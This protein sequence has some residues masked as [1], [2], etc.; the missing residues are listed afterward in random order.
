[1][2]LIHFIKFIMSFSAD[3]LCFLILLTCVGCLGL[4]TRQE[5]PLLRYFCWNQ[6]SQRYQYIFLEE[7]HPLS[8]K[9]RSVYCWDEVSSCFR[10]PFGNL[11]PVIINEK[12]SESLGK[13]PISGSSANLRPGEFSKRYPVDNK[14]FQ[15]A[16]EFP[17]HVQQQ[18][19]SEKHKTDVVMPFVVSL[20]GQDFINDPD[21]SEENSNSKHTKEGATMPFI[22]S[23]NT[24]S[25]N[26]R[27]NS[28]AA[29]E[30]LT[31]SNEFQHPFRRLNTPTNKYEPIVN[32]VVY[33]NARNLFHGSKPM[34][35]NV[36][37]YRKSPFIKYYGQLINSNTNSNSYELPYEVTYD[38]TISP[39]AYRYSSYNGIRSQTRPFKIKIQ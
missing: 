27:Q 18:S 11:C 39:V 29:T 13:S 32:R 12:D 20:N 38:H 37:N 25:N 35:Y 33:N 30:S 15:S 23:L 24:N 10:L 14:D 5:V 21:M 6:A 22:V 28:D 1:M 26:A 2:N 3:K 17:K 9:P 16:N 36:A 19:T 4:E 34:S 31:S 8:P 7:C